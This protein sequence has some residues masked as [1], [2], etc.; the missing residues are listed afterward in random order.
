[1]KLNKKEE[2]E[3]EID[4]SPMIDMVFLL[5]I[6]FIV[7]SAIVKV[8]P[9]KIEVPMA[10]Y[11]KVP[12]DETG[13]FKITVNEEGAMFVGLTSDQVDLDQ[14]QQLLIPEIEANGELK[15]LIRSDLKTKYEH[16]E[17][18][19]MAC[20]EVGAMDMIFTAFEK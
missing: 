20:A 17:K 1:M 19:M 16:N 4:M 15:V 5:L 11:A 8:D 2:E 6:F 7:A 12:E 3:V 14:L 13:R 9:V 18:I 10:V